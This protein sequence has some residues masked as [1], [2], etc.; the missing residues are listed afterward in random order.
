MISVSGVARIGTKPELK[1]IG[2]GKDKPVCE[3]RVYLS[4]GKYDENKNWIDR[5]YWCDLSVWGACAQSAAQLLSK[6]DRVYVSG[7]QH[8][9]KWMHNE[10]EYSQMKID[11]N[12]LSPYM[13]DLE[14]I[15]FKPRKGKQGDSSESFQSENGFEHSVREVEHSA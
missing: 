15:S 14:A 5:S 10:K 12:V 3:M 8:L 7:Y 2:P 11:A 9:H 13:P 1:M 4:S 6:G